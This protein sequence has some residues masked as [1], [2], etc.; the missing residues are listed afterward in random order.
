MSCLAAVRSLTCIVTCQS[1]V[2]IIARRPRLSTYRLSQPQ[3]LLQAPTVS[4]PSRMECRRRVSIQSASLAGTPHHLG[5]IVR[6]ACGL[7]SCG[8]CGLLQRSPY[9][10][11]AWRTL[12]ASVFHV[13]KVIPCLHNRHH[14]STQSTMIGSNLA[15]NF[16]LAIL[17]CD[18]TV[19]T[20]SPLA[21]A[22]SGNE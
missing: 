4:P 6:E 15:R 9:S 2:G 20:P 19:L 3:R 12:L 1:H 18:V 7:A 17:A 13:P 8:F 22:I 5:H 16:S 14:A 21:S 11:V 10:C